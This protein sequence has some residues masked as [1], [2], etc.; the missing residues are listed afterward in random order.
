MIIK[1]IISIA[2][3]L[4]LL[5]VPQPL[6]IFSSQ[7]TGAPVVYSDTFDYSN[8]GEV[9]EFYGTD[10]WEAEYSA[11]NESDDFGFRDSTPPT[12]SDGKL[13][14]Q[15]GDAV[16]LNWQKLEGF[17]DFDV[18]KTYTVSFDVI[19]MDTGTHSFLDNV[20]NWN[21]ELYFA[22]GGYYNQIE[23]R[24][25]DVDNDTANYG[26][27]AG[28]T[29]V[30]VDAIV[31]D[32]VYSCSV[33]WTPA[34]GT[35]KT[36]IRNGDSVVV[37]GS[38]THED[39][40]TLNKYTRSLVWR[41]EDGEIAVDNIV[42]S[43]GTHTYQQDFDTGVGSMIESGI[44]GIEDVRVTDSRIPELVDGKLKLFTHSG[45]KFNWMQ[46]PGVSPYS[47]TNTYTFEFD[48]KIT[49]TGNGNTWD[50]DIYR[51]R[52]LYVG[53][54]G[55]YT[56]LSVPDQNNKIDVCYGNSKIA[57]VDQQHLNAVLHA[58]FTWSGSSISGK[59][60]DANGNV[61]VAG[62]RQNAA[63]TD[64]TVEKA[65]MTNLVLRC[66]DG[67]VEIDNFR[68]KEEKP[69]LLERV[70]LSSQPVV[71]SAKIEYS[72]VGSV[73]VKLGEKALLEITPTT[74]SACTKGINAHFGGGTYQLEATINP[75]QQMVTVELIA[76]SGAM[77]ES[78][79]YQLLEDNDISQISVSATKGNKLLSS[80]VSNISV[81]PSLYTFVESEPVYSGVEANI[82]NVV[83]SFDDAQTTRNFAWTANASF[84][85]N[86]AMALQ[87][88]VK[89]ASQWTVVDASR[90]NEAY[91]VSSEDYFKCDIQGLAPNTAYEYKIGI[92]DS[93]DEVN[94]WSK[95]YSFKTAAAQ[96]TDFSFIAIGD[97]QGYSWNEMK[98]TRAAY[99][100]AFKALSE[101]AFIVHT[102]DVTDLGGMRRLWN[103]FFKALGDYATSTPF[104][105]TIGNHDTWFTKTSSYPE[106]DGNLYFD[107]HFN[108]PNNGGTAALDAE[109]LAGINNQNLIYLTQNADE[110]IYSYNYG[111]VHFI[112]LN[113]GSYD[114]YNDS[115]LLRA[116][117][118]WLKADLEANKDAKWII[119]F[120]H[121]PV[122]HRL[123]G[124]Q[125]RGNGI[126]SD[127]IEEYGVDLVI[128]GHSHLVTRTYPMKDG[129]VT[130]KLVSDTIEEGTGTI[131]M[132]IGS[133]SLNHDGI[134]DTSYVEEMYLTATST[135]QQ[136]AYTIVDIKDGNLT[137]TTKQLNGLVLDQF[138]I[139]G[140]GNHENDPDNQ[141][142]CPEIVQP[143]VEYVKDQGGSLYS[144]VLENG[145]QFQ[146]ISGIPAEYYSYSNGTL[147]IDRAYLQTLEAGKYFYTLTYSRAQQAVYLTL[148]V[149]VSDTA[150]AENEARTLSAPKILA[151]LHN[152]YIFGSSIPTAGMGDGVILY[153][154]SK[155][156]DIATVSQWQ[157]IGILPPSDV[158]AVYYIFA[159]I[160]NGQQYEDAFSTGVPVNAHVHIWSTEI[161]LPT[162]D[163][164]GYTTYRCDRCGYAY[165]DNFVD[166][167][168][169]IRGDVDGNGIVD[170]IDV[171][172]LLKYVNRCDAD[173]LDLV[174]DINQDGKVN[175]LDA[176]TLLYSINGKIP[177]LDGDATNASKSGITKVTPD[178]A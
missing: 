80:D 170:L 171:K 96:I 60:T 44:W 16:R 124:N 100:E 102:G 52:T 47:V 136:A 134:I 176:A 94:H 131:Y 26:I 151:T 168:T 113:S 31:T 160:I 58:T 144:Y 50:G 119:L 84:V 43:D 135:P 6:S 93:T 62:S 146:N 99:D 4:I 40:K 98:Y 21:R 159:K 97:T 140:S 49:D 109:Q 95:T 108:H 51:T 2:L 24:S 143:Y 28:N 125:D 123:G 82:Y 166:A 54:G 56:L 152:Q 42:L 132:T 86:N 34:N 29:W 68:F 156:N 9:I 37:S 115:A 117:Y 13:Y 48:F 74:I 162:L 67:T 130:T 105:A 14:F 1:R 70:D 157:E 35:I 25:G 121:Q 111:D 101:P 53:F 158:D 46:V 65:A 17:S 85:G 69:E 155:I 59:I 20:T 154:Y 163:A 39:F 33:V 173:T 147:V 126:Y 116:Q 11:Q 3:C 133:C 138:T 83:T 148:T 128:Q 107:Y 61:L 175:I 177:A 106:N 120:Q 90:E 153:G 77:V 87:Y 75:V 118:D 22:P 76:P 89:G 172:T 55:W 19:V 81:A 145:F 164:G 161:T 169:N 129:K 137:V 66:E 167:L 150:G 71:Y 63:F 10:A 122:Y 5:P 178:G 165:Q 103:L 27:R 79:F 141:K 104:F 92:K 38:R 45:V 8:F 114:N 91:E 88:R 112:S 78:S 149:K 41:C 142:P 64:M 127:L 57:W 36:T 110:T 174:Y 18:A 30:G 23:I 15:K 12:I 7:E 72:G 139:V 73:S 32:M